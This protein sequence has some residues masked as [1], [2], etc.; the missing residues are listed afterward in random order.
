VSALEAQRGVPRDGCLSEIVQ[1]R[2]GGPVAKQFA[3]HPKGE[4]GPDP[5]PISPLPLVR[6]FLEPVPAIKSGV[7]PSF[8]SL[9]S[10]SSGLSTNAESRVS[11]SPSRTTTSIP[12]TA[13]ESRALRRPTLPG[14]TLP[15]T[16]A[17][18]RAGHRSFRRL[19]SPKSPSTSWNRASRSS[20]RVRERGEGRAMRP[21][22]A[23]SQ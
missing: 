10:Y 19:V 23:R 12:V 8:V 21:H 18:V 3:V 14:S 22:P 4:P 1:D 6:Y 7:K 15:I 20:G 13:S 5:F 17:S 2:R 11:S 9:S 16:V